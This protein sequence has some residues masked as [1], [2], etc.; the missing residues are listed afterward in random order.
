MQYHDYKIIKRESIPE[1]LK[2][3]ETRE[4]IGSKNLVFE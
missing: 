4:N 3:H 1:I 2:I